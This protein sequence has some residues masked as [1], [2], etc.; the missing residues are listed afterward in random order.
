MHIKR[1]NN[2]KLALI[3]L[4]FLN[5]LIRDD[6]RICSWL[7]T[8]QIQI[9]E[10]EETLDCVVSQFQFPGKLRPGDCDCFMGGGGAGFGTRSSDWK[11]CSLSWT[12]LS[13]RAASGVTQLWN[14]AG[15]S[16]MYLRTFWCPHGWQKH[17]P[18]SSPAYMHLQHRLQD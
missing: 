2:F 13:C 7:A 18:L 10:L 12:F 16:A 17:S 15:S 1:R 6:L 9:L 3:S 4:S 8:Q 5:W 11:L 14:L